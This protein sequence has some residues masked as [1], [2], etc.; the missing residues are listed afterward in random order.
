MNLLSI[1]FTLDE[2][3]RFFLHHFYS[4]ILELTTVLNAFN[5]FETWSAC[6]SFQNCIYSSRCEY[7]LNKQ[8]SMWKKNN[9]Y[10]FVALA[11]CWF[12]C[13]WNWR[14]VDRK[15][16]LLFKCRYIWIN[17]LNRF[18]QMAFDNQENRKYGGET[19]CWPQNQESKRM[20]LSEWMRLSI[21]KLCSNKP[22]ECS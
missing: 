11:K 17:E 20:D 14:N 6:I 10:E 4:Y 7:L 12:V 3:L 5:W 8:K 21:R 18:S 9:W 15:N 13:S 19:I 16:V 2:F 22:I 1:F